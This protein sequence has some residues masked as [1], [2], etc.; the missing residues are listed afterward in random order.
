MPQ[1]KRLP[2]VIFANGTGVT[3]SKYPTLFQ[4]LASWGFIVI[5]NEDPGSGNGSSS[6]KSVAFLLKQNEDKTSPIYHKADINDIGIS[7]HSQGGAGVF[8]AITNAKY[9]KYYKTAVAMSPTNEESAAGLKWGYN[10]TLVDIPTLLL[11]GDKGDFETKLVLPI[12]KMKQTYKK[13]LCFSSHLSFTI[14]PIARFLNEKDI[15]YVIKDSEKFFKIFVSGL[16][17]AKSRISIQKL[18]TK[19]GNICIIELTFFCPVR[20]IRLFNSNC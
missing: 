12:E 16:I 3:A 20:H 11:A 13:I 1:S 7:G 2:V 6:D 14:I 10:P 15:D 4:H 5:G 18:L 9:G 17:N 8:N 19:I